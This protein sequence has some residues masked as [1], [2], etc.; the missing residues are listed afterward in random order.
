[1]RRRARGELEREVLRTLWA[2]ESGMTSS[3]LWHSFPAETRPARTTLLTILSRLEDKGSVRRTPAPHGA[4]FTATVP[5]AV[6]AA[7]S[8]QGALATATDRRAALTHFAGSLD[9]EDAQLLRQL[10][11]G[12]P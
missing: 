1:M 6:H 8:M 11:D 12:S 2:A 4:S 9:H 3:E 5:E 10:L 7:S